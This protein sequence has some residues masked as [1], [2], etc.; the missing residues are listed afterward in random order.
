MDKL[1]E[2]LERIKSRQDLAAFVSLLSDDLFSNSQDW[3]NVSLKDYLGAIAAWCEDMDGYF[4][5]LGL[6]V[7]QSPSWQTIAQILL[8]A[9]SYE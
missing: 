7:P 5:N 3:E 4:I 8:A 2:H 9:R 6:P 1:Q